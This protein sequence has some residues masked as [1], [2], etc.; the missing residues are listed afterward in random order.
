MSRR[1]FLQL[2]PAALAI[3]VNAQSSGA[4]VPFRVDVPEA[5]I[6]RI[7]NRVRETRLPSRLAA[8]DW[9][10]GVNWDYMQSLVEYWTNRFDWRKAE[11][12]LNRFP[13]F[14]TRIDGYDI[15]FY[16]V[17]GRGPRPLPLVLTHGWPGSVFEFLEAIGPLS[18]PARFGGTAE[19]AFD[20]IVPSIP[21]FGFSS[22][23]TAPIGHPT[24]ARLWHSL[25]TDVLGYTS[26]G[27]Q[28]G[29][30]GSGVTRE[31]AIAFPRNVIGIHVNGISAVSMPSDGGSEE[32]KRWQ[33]ANQ[34]FRDVE[35]DYFREHQRKPSTVEFALHDNPVGTAAWMTEKFKIWS[36]SGDDIERA[37]TKDQLLTN[38]MIYLVTETAGT[39][40]WLYR[41]VADEPA[42]TPPGGTLNTPLGF[43]SFPAEMPPLNPPRTLVERN[44]NL[45]H[46]TKMP[47]GGH[48]A[49]LEQPALFVEDVRQFFRKVRT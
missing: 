37:F 44:H 9:R 1:V 7:M 12:N 4:P 30:L 43:A 6:V 18:D 3:P 13:Q 38:I 31:L 22:K 14:R 49:C 32:E 25:M 16:H 2:V 36:D 11:A 46:Y 47:K 33:A 8:P 27:A 29:D 19:D 28:G 34:R 42:S 24:I 10:Y 40:V 20:V 45:V 35:F 48:F 23:P 21:G 5:A 39:A 26:F 15:H 17:R 41:G